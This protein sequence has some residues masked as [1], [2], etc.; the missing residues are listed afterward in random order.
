MMEQNTKKTKVLVRDL[1]V[2]DTTAVSSSPSAS[3]GAASLP[4][5]QTTTAMP[6]LMV[7][8]EIDFV[9]SS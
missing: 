3:A 1:S 6:D 2:I 7:E 8:R 5:G 9:S 4:A